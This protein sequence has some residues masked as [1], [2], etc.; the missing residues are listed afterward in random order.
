MA[1]H[2]MMLLA[3]EGD[4]AG[5]NINNKITSNKKREEA[6]VSKCALRSLASESDCEFSHVVKI[7]E[8]SS[9]ALPKRLFN[10]HLLELTTTAEQQHSGWVSVHPSIS[11]TPSDVYRLTFDAHVKSEIAL[12]SHYLFLFFTSFLHR[13]RERKAQ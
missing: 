13:T 1:V 2:M 9:S 12:F 8:T 4:I 3:S 6:K 11:L 10:N 5:E 7:S